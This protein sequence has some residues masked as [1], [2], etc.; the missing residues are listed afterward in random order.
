MDFGFHRLLIVPCCRRL[1]VLPYGA[2]G[3]ILTV[4]FCVL[5]AWLKS[6]VICS[7]RSLMLDVL[8][9]LF[10]LPCVML[11]WKLGPNI[12]RS[13]AVAVNCHILVGCKNTFGENRNGHVCVGNLLSIWNDTPVGNLVCFLC[14]CHVFAL[15][16]VIFV[17]LWETYFSLIS[18]LKLWWSF[19]S[20]AMNFSLHGCSL[21]QVPGVFLQRTWFC[22]CKQ[23]LIGDC[24]DLELRAA[25]FR[26]LW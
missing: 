12:L 21:D 8:L 17:P 4:C 15:D 2:M 6:I 26:V 7:L 19:Q 18:I 13:S 1:P 11:K 3:L 20:T 10:L 5:N 25:T 22:S 23:Q 9:R 14:E 24:R 16:T